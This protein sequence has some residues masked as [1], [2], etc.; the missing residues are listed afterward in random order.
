[1]DIYPQDLG[2]T[3]GEEVLQHRFRRYWVDPNIQ[4]MSTAKAFFA[5]VA[6]TA[7]SMSYNVYNPQITNNPFITYGLIGCDVLLAG[8]FSLQAVRGAIRRTL[9][10]KP[11]SGEEIKR[12]CKD[13]DVL[14]QKYILLLQAIV[15]TRTDTDARAQNDV[16]Q[17]VRSLYS[18]IEKLPAQDADTAADDPAALQQE[19]QHIAA[20]AD[21]EPDSV[22]RASLRRRAQSLSHRAA[23]AERTDLLL[24]RNAALRAEVAEQM[25]ALHTSLTALK[26]GATQGAGE[27]AGL[28]ASIQSVASAAN[29]ITGAR[30]EVDSFLVAPEENLPLQRGART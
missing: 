18:A 12:I 22:I 7:L 20:Q 3:L 6:A 26:V 9:A 27:L 11:L 16:R 17:A 29:A 2:E 19:A 23:T 5:F 28:A 14:A 21:A 8:T 25:E 15:A 1:M 24:R 13:N 10:R 30:T 4:A